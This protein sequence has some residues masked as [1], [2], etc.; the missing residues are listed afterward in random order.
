ML[1][2]DDHPSLRAGVRALLDSEPDIEVVAEAGSAAE[3]RIA[4]VKD[5]PDVSVV[6]LQLPDGAGEELIAEFVSTR[7]EAVILALTSFD[8]SET[9]KRTL[10]AGAR[11]YL[12]KSTASQEIVDAVRSS[13]GG[14]R[15]VKG[16]V[17]ERLA[18]AMLQEDLTPR[19][20]QVLSAL[21]SG[22]GNK[23]IARALEIS[24][25]T[26]KLHIGHILSKLQAKTRTEAIMIA[27]KTGLIRA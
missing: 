10:A 13:H 19:E 12:M 3:A 22:A 4:F 21:T 23:E 24:E 26:V 6:D 15:V 27:L 25:A 2:V 9:I 5:R 11:G 14:R 18:E 8:G 16:L 1:I 7:P 20:M 17:A